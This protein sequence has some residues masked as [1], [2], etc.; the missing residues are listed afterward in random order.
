MASNYFN[1]VQKSDPSGRHSFFHIVSNEQKKY[2]ETGKKCY[3]IEKNKE[4]GGVLGQ[5]IGS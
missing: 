2:L 3:I 4:G 1:I 5:E